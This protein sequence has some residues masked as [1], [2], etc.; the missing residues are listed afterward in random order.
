MTLNAGLSLCLA[1]DGG[2]S[3]RMT[4]ATC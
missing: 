4:T 1:L 2:A 3:Y